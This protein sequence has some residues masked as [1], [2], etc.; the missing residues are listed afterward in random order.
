MKEPISPRSSS[1]SKWLRQILDAGFEFVRRALPSSYGMLKKRRL[2]WPVLV[3]FVASV[4]AI[5][6]FIADPYFE[7]KEKRRVFSEM[8]AAIIPNNSSEYMSSY[9]II[10]NELPKSIR[11]TRNSDYW[12]N[13]SRI[14][15][16]H[17]TRLDGFHKSLA[18]AFVRGEVLSSADE[19]RRRLCER[20]TRL[21]RTHSKIEK[22]LDAVYGLVHSDTDASVSVFGPVVVVPRLRY[23][24]KVHNNAC[25][26]EW[27]LV[28]VKTPSPPP[29][30]QSREDVMRTELAETCEEVQ[31]VKMASKQDYDELLRRHSVAFIDQFTT[32][33]MKTSNTPYVH[34]QEV[35][36]EKLAS[37]IKERGLGTNYLL[38]GMNDIVDNIAAVLRYRD[39]DF[40]S[41]LQSLKKKACVS[42][43]GLGLHEACGWTC[44]G[45]SG[46]A[47]EHEDR[48]GADGRQEDETAKVLPKAEDAL[49]L[50]LQAAKEMTRVNLLQVSVV[51]QIAIRKN[52]SGDLVGATQSFAE[53]LAVA[54]RL[55]HEGQRVEAYAQIAKAQVQAGDV[56]GATRSIEVALEISETIEDKGLQVEALTEIA[57]A[58]VKSGDVSGATRS[59]AA[60][61][62]AAK[63]IDNEYLRGSALARI[64]AAELEAGN[65]RGA[66][67]TAATI[68][69]DTYS[70]HAFADIAVW[71]ANAGGRFG[72]EI[73]H[74]RRYVGRHA[75]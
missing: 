12:S 53:A 30:P 66:V 6:Q 9:N 4:F 62:E 18:D 36:K 54:E 39:R 15:R 74:R 28:D 5:W 17:I 19:H 70:S 40:G 42:A 75:H 35:A 2:A 23:M 61:R 33:L 48:V 41:E 52:L 60:S 69:D 1:L 59:I 3:G 73:I 67:M 68:S 63:R 10:A 46:E 16:K 26:E 65:I 64:S 20:I 49:A 27:P 8:S 21:L 43:Q 50:A 56:L 13:F 37:I 51:V 38:P 24:P 55:E 14:W 25:G 31:W 7:R 57:K 72:C 58:Q 45:S 11:Q 29:I 71:K 32:S 44:N 34:A 47:F 22:D